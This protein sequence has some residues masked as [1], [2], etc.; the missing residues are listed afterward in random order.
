MLRFDA[1]CNPL[2][3]GMIKKILISASA[4]FEQVQGTGIIPASLPD[5]ASSEQATDAAFF[6]SVAM[7]RVRRFCQQCDRLGH[8][9]C[10]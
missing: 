4:S 7:V 8:V 10:L 2:E 9:M 6:I 3:S 5:V 1:I